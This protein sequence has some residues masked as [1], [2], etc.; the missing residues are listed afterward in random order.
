MKLDLQLYGISVSATPAGVTLVLNG[1]ALRFSRGEFAALAHAF[2][3]VE[4]MLARATRTPAA[5]EPT[6]ADAAPAPEVALSPTGKKR[7]RPP[8]NAA[9]AVAAPVATPAAVSAAPAPKKRGRPPKNASAVV[10]AAP[11]AVAAVVPAA[12]GPKKRGRPPKNAAVAVAAPVA[13]GEAAPKKRGRPPKNPAAT[14]SI[15]AEIAAAGKRRGRPP[16]SLAAAAKAKIKAAGPAAEDGAKRGPG[17]PRTDGTAVGARRLVELVDA[18]MAENPGPKSM[19]ELAAAAEK[20]G[21]VDAAHAVEFLE[22]HVP[23]SPAL[24]VR[25]PDGRFRRRADKVP[26]EA[27]KAAKLLRRRGHDEVAIV[28]V[29]APG[30]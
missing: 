8:K 20:L 21:W 15:A 14:T 22:R 2:A 23:R 7:G 11:P 28:R 4:D 18:W 3:S 19:V 24:F 1:T 29:E 12:T 5:A 9:V 16:K 27:P 6:L 10:A 30:T 26:V 13:A 25:M 17:R